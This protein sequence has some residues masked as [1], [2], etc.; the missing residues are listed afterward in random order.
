[1]GESRASVVAGQWYSI[2]AQSGYFYPDVL[3]LIVID[4]DW[5]RV[6]LIVPVLQSTV[7]VQLVMELVLGVKDDPLSVLVVCE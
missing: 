1:M 6:Q 5:E 4:L 3:R 7:A 2:A